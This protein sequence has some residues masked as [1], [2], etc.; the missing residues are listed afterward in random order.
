MKTVNVATSADRRTNIGETKRFLKKKY[1][2]IPAMMDK[3]GKPTKT[4]KKIS[5]VKITPL[6]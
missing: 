5:N 4:M 1:P 6:V 3:I 2:R